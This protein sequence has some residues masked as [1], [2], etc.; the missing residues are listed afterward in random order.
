MACVGC[1]TGQRHA[2]ALSLDGK[3]AKDPPASC[4]RCGRTGLSAGERMVG[5]F[6]LV[7]GNTLC[8]SC[9]NREREVVHGANAKGGR[10]TIFLRESRVRIEQDGRT[11]LVNLGLCSGKPEAERVA[12]RRWPGCVVVSFAMDADPPPIVPK[13][14]PIAVACTSARF[15]TGF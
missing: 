9:Y 7:R 6:R 14:R 15:A 13:H 3:Q 1:P 4:V 11:Q 8:V 5:R 12:A 10:P 2:E